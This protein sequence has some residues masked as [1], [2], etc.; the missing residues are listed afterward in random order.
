VQSAPAFNELEPRRP[1]T[2]LA[3]YCVRLSAQPSKRSHLFVNSG[4]LEDGR[5]YIAR[6]IIAGQGLAQGK[7]ATE[8]RNFISDATAFKSKLIKATQ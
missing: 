5:P 4:T 1:E 3:E 7:L 2:K 8:I 6:I